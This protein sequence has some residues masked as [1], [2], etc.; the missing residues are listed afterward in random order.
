MKY[1]DDPSY[2]ASFS[3]SDDVMEEELVEEEIIEEEIIE[4]DDDEEIIEEEFIE[5][6]IEEEEEE[7]VV[8]VEQRAK[9]KQ[10]Q[11]QKR[12]RKPKRTRKRPTTSDRLD[13]NRRF[14]EQ[15]RMGSS[16]PST[17]TTKPTKKKV[18]NAKLRTKAGTSKRLPRKKRDPPASTFHYTKINSTDDDASTSTGT[19]SWMIDLTPLERPRGRGSRSRAPTGPPQNDPLDE[20]WATSW[21]MPPIKPIT[22]SV[23]E[24]LRTTPPPTPPSEEDE[25]VEEVPFEDE[26][27][28]TEIDEEALVRRYAEPRS[29]VPEPMPPTPYALKTEFEKIL[30]WENKKIWC[31]RTKLLLLFVFSLAGTFFVIYLYVEIDKRKNENTF[32][33]RKQDNIFSRIETSD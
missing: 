15:L 21:A 13:S 18:A 22:P 14:V 29:V 8:Q 2:Y 28:S 3:D 12:N 4:E 23:Q 20:Y 17:S 9:F 19:N 33:Q 7:Q 16:V 11:K 1:D 24:V 31:S 32:N 30:Y 27:E 25:I 5:E 6:I 10:Q 26:D